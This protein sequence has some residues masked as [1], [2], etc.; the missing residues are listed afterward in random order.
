MLNNT[1][2]G[3]LDVNLGEKLYSHVRIQLH[4]FPLKYIRKMGHGHE[5]DRGKSR[6]GLRGCKSLVMEDLSFLG[7]FTFLKTRGLEKLKAS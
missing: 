4:P 5:S 6:S 1:K 3:N 2:E 7:P